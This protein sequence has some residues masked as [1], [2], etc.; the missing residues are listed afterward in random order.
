MGGIRPP[1][2]ATAPGLTPYV[3]RDGWETGRT[4]RKRKERNRCVVA[5]REVVTSQTGF[6]FVSLSCSA[7]VLQDCAALSKMLGLPEPPLVVGRGR[8]PQLP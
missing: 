2:A 4:G 1:Q 6:K 5:K 7:L 8:C 3:Y